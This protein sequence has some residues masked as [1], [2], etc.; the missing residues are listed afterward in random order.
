VSAYGPLSA[1]F[2]D[3]DKPRAGDE[4]VAWYAGRLPRD[5][6][7]ILEAMCGSG[8]LLLPLAQAGFKLHGVDSS[9]AM[10][11]SCEARLRAAG[12]SPVLFRQ[13][14]TGLNVPFRY[15]AAFIAAGSFQLLTDPLGARLALERLRAH[16]LPGA[17]LLLDL[18]VPE[19]ARHP[20]GAPRVDVRSVRLAD[21]ARITLRGETQVDAQSR[22]IDFRYRYERREPARPI[23][24]EDEALSITWYERDDIVAL[25]GE[26]G[27]ADVSVEPPAFGDGA[28]LAFAVS[29]RVLAK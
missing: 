17:L 29:A 28:E 4:E 20:P 10:L 19:E 21:G 2:Y 5:A 9:A 25:V 24:R 8:R 7:T 15:A 23:V 27:F 6:G 3:A 11:A 13:D 12:H 18:V 1:A 26:A 16:L 22:L 14:I